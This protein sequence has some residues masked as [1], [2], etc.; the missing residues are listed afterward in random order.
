MRLYIA[1]KPSMGAEIAKCLTGPIQRKDGYLITKD[2]IVTWAFGHILRQ[3]EPDEYNAKY[4][5]WKSEDLP[6]IPQQ[7]KMIID[8]KCKKQFEII[9]GLIS[10]ADEIVHAGDPDREGQ[11]LIDEV[12]DF[13]NCKKPVKRILLNALDEE[14][15]KKANQNLRDNQDFVN[16]KKSAL[17]RA[18][19]DWLIGMNLSRAY[20]LAA[21]RA[22][23]KGVFA[24]GRVKTPTLALVVR[25]ERE[26]KD[27]KPVDYFIIKAL[28]KHQNGQFVA[29]WKPQDTQK[30]LDS[31]N[32]LLDENI[33][34]ELI[35]KF[36]QASEVNEYGKIIAYQKAQKKEAQRLPFS[37]SSLQVLAGKRFGYDP[38]LVLDTA[39]SLYEKKL[40]T[41]PRSDC[42]YLPQSQ[43]NDAKIILHNL[44]NID[45]PQL[46]QWSQKTDVK[47]KSRAWNDKKITAHHAIIPTKVK[48][49]LQSL[50]QVQQ[51]IYY[52]IAQAYIA[53]FY[54][55][56][57]YDQTKVS[58]EY[59]QEL[60]T[61]SG[62][63]EKQ[64]GWKELYMQNNKTVTSNE[65]DKSEKEEHEDNEEN[66]SLP[67]MKKGDEV[68]Y[69][70]GKYDKK[71]TKPPTRF[72]GATLL[73]GMKDIHKYVKDVEVKKKLKDIYGIGT[74]ATR[75]SIIDDL[76]KR[77]FLQIEGKKKYLVPT[78]SAYI[79]VDA[80]PDEM[81]YP[82]S[83]AIWEDYLH[84]L[85]EG[86]GSI[87]EFLAKQ[88]EFTKNL[89]QKATKVVLAKENEYA[90]P[91]CK[92][93]IL[94]KRNG[95]NGVFWGC[96][97]FPICRMTCNDVDGKPA[98]NKSVNNSETRNNIAYNTYVQYNNQEYNIQDSGI[99]S[100]LDL[101]AKA[102]FNQQSNRYTKKYSAKPLEITSKNQANSKYLCTRC[103][104]GHLRRIRGKNG[105]FWACSNYPH[106]TATYDDNQ[107]MPVLS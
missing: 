5:F 24:V 88:V 10:K 29:T 106:C 69:V 72:T 93:G 50:N 70:D 79:L 98:I 25:R 27:F 36:K 71:S 82:D 48:V 58:I 67:L 94:V 41:Y 80:L 34:K 57:I 18:R 86:S 54:P 89:C 92:Q 102:N 7:W 100:A 104:E 9:K 66:N 2:G 32:R 53:Q 65:E 37:L 39:Q 28:F 15:I 3:A 103:K 44:M 33:A 22:G 47:I 35:A 78:E 84:S 12:L 97:N 73:A 76:L 52:L 62:R 68:S 31:E 56:H 30:G 6:I 61:T 85:S 77:G 14:S 16:L 99:I 105:W 8:E 40:T 1:E 64:L 83:T 38:Q 42:E 4:K 46:A 91:R 51:N 74:E 90:C 59:T 17:A 26:L 75:A 107:E 20:T 13:V 87:D 95:K 11:L 21:R 49:N 60:F 96:S 19:A 63:V 23:K 43:F 101:V 45:N 55:V 81:T